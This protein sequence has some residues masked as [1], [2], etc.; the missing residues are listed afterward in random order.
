MKQLNIKIGNTPTVITVVNAKSKAKVLTPNEIEM[1]R[2]AENAVKNA[3]KKARICKKP[4]AEY[5]RLTK[6]VTIN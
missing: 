1:D 6:T 5:D 4:V 2:L 3:I